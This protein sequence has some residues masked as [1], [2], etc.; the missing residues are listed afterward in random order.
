MDSGGL[1]TRERQRY[2][3]HLLIPED[4]TDQSIA[5]SFLDSRRNR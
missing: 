1:T 3:R 5:A 4:G 2:S